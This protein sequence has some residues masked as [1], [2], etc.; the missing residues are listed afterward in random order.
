MAKP[1]AREDWLLDVYKYSQEFATDKMTVMMRELG[2]TN[3]AALRD[4]FKKYTKFL[5]VKN[6]KRCLNRFQFLNI[7]KNKLTLLY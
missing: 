7:Q 6:V 2:I 1:L 3:D 5:R 4:V